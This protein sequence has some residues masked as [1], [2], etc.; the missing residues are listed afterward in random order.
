MG[1]DRNTE[2]VGLHRLKRNFFSLFYYRSPINV[3]SVVL[4]F[5]RSCFDFIREAHYTPGSSGWLSRRDN[6]TCVPD[7]ATILIRKESVDQMR[8][9]STQYGYLHPNLEPNPMG[10]DV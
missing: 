6:L 8:A 3:K 4:K 9:S 10:L 1:D 5:L 2:K 7:I